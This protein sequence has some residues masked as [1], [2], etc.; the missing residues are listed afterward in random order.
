MNDFIAHLSENEIER[1]ALRT[2]KLLGHAE[3]LRLPMVEILE[4]GIP[5]LFPGCE[6]HVDPTE[7]MGDVEAYVANV[8]PRIVLSERTYDKVWAEDNRIRFTIAHEFGHIFFHLGY[9]DSDSGRT[10]RSSSHKLSFIAK[11][12]R[13]ANR[14]AVHFLLPEWIA[15]KFPEP[16]KLAAT[17]GVSKSAAR[18]RLEELDLWP[19]KSGLIKAGFDDLLNELRGDVEPPKRKLSSITRLESWGQ[20]LYDKQ[21]DEF[22][23]IV[24]AG[25]TPAPCA[26]IGMG[27]VIIG[28]CNQ[29]CIACYGN[30]EGL[31]KKILSQPEALHIVDAISEA[32]I[33]R[34]VISGGEP[35]LLPYLPKVIEALTARG[36]SVV[37]GTNGTFL[38][39]DNI[40]AL[41]ECTRVEISLD[42]P[43]AGL[44]NQLRPSKD[45]GNAWTEAI[46]AIKLCLRHGIKLRVLT[47]LSRR[48][49][50][51][52]VEMAALLQS[53]G[54][55]DW[56]LSW[57]IPAGRAIPIFQD[58]QPEQ[59]TIESQLRVVR[60]HFPALTVRYSHRDA[61]FDRYYFLIL[62]DGQIATQHLNR[63]EKATF[64][65]ALDI[66]IAAAWNQQNFDLLAH[67]KKWVAGRISR[68]Y[69]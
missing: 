46:Q 35:L 53:I 55:R 2:R 1:A 41:T 60:V 26:P 31:P 22:S 52:I 29:K 14:F 61:K 65:S 59:Q 21:K 63:P 62:P 49:Q 32:G 64:G 34:V 33:M 38:N 47:T 67:F 23:A 42:A 25:V 27:W 6:I 17:C 56:A 36:V 10:E 66:P 20:I 18:R 57:T 68:T 43:S 50:N 51:T 15:R 28:G 11:S 30:A 45:G 16:A 9:L 5:K 40:D 19:P 58:L 39:A 69:D 12:E 44:N 37:L 24:R 13:Q 8:P 3:T 7:Q 48:N 54:V 4:L